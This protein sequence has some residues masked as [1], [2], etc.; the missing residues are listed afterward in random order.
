MENTGKTFRKILISSALILKALFI[1]AESISLS[2]ENASWT[3]VM[4]GKAILKPEN[5]S[6]GFAVLTDGRTL[7]GFSENGKELWT[8]RT[9]SRN[10]GF[11]SVLEKDF[12]VLVS[13]KSNV[14]LIN[15]S[16]NLLWT[17]NIGFPVT[18]KATIGKDGRI[19]IQGKNN[20]ACLGVNGIEKWR[21]KTPSLKEIR[22]Q[23]LDD[24]TLVAF[25]EKPQDK[26]TAGIRFTPFGEALETITF[27]SLV[28]DAYSSEHGIVLSFLSGGIGLVSAG[29][30]EKTFTEWAIPSEDSAF[31]GALPSKGITL[32]PLDG[33][34]SSAL[35]ENT[36]GKVKIIFFENRT[37]KI[38]NIFHIPE[39]SFSRLTCVSK[40]SGT[41]AIFLSD[42]KNALIVNPEGKHLY[43]ARLPGKEG[44]NGWNY[45]FCTDQN[46]LVMTGNSWTLNAFRTT[47]N[48]KKKNA[49]SGKKPPYPYRNFFSQGK[50]SSS[51]DFLS[52]QN[53]F[54]SINFTDF[55][56]RNIY[57]EETKK[58]LVSGNYGNQETDLSARIFRFT[59]EYLKA[60]S[61]EASYPRFKEQDGF[62]TDEKNLAGTFSL[63]PYF[64][65]DE[66][67][68]IIAR[69]IKAETNETV[70]NTL[71]QAAGTCAY[72]PE[73]LML[74]ALS[75]KIK[76]IPARNSRLL[77]SLSDS[78]FEICRF[79]GRPA[80]YSYGMEIQK[81]FLYPQYPSE[82]RE[83]ARKNLSETARLNQ[84]KM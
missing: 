38:H 48:V 6:Y 17:K 57:S 51:A 83:T 4:N 18:E 29:G 67:P 39:I 30:K 28:S 70:L 1:F 5:T 84:S 21:M 75:A 54:G 53:S 82:V 64:G 47:M 24:G 22:I 40:V 73:N 58:L 25:L 81:T 12:I 31:S 46:H 32:A 69:L 44:I 15:P 55:F 74:D 23:E 59:E 3:S 27:T 77:V 19:I 63:L 80:L 7:N 52:S 43:E 26:R 16:G 65:T 2:H 78:V 68:R 60:K 10:P 49:K 34:I 33:D 41:E 72:D 66:P 76:S 13:D 42:E 50:N 61:T 36:G 14:S 8:A 45:V 35:M 71:I 37:G 56:S 79:M 62:R 20:I 9:K 11:I